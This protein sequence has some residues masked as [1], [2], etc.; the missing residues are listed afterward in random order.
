V[1]PFL[2]GRFY[3]SI[4]LR[5]QIS[6]VM[7]GEREKQNCSAVILRRPFIPGSIASARTP[8]M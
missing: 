6:L 1:P 5:N 8:N 3:R 4:P 2:S 7:P